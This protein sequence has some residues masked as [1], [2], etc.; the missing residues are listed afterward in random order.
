[1]ADQTI[2]GVFHQIQHL[3]ESFGTAMVRIGHHRCVMRQT[4]LRQPSHFAEMLGWAIIL[5]KRQV[6]SVHHQNQVVL[7][8]VI[9][10]DLARPQIRQ[11]VSSFFCMHLGPC[12]G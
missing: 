2:T 8:K 12:V 5:H 10:G 1:M 6:V 11:V 3:I 4:E 7:V 9:D